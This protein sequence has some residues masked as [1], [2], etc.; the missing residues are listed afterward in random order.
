MWTIYHNPR[1][2]KSRQTLQLLQE[3]NIEPE[4]VLYLETPP[5]TAIL[6]ALLKKLGIGAR[7]LLRKGEDAYKELNLKD[8]T[9]G[10]DA[11][12]QAMVTH[13]K[14]IERPIVVNGEKAVLGRPPE[15]V[16]ELL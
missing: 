7:D 11:L 5:D 1:C 9:L 2:S 14:L 10:D 13:P 16:L 4:V 8:P 15:N 12:I 3:N 6:T